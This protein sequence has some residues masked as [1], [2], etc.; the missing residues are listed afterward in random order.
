MRTVRAE[1]RASMLIESMRDFGY[2]LESAVA[3][4]VDNSIT[5]RALTV[6]IFADSTGSEPRIG[7][8]DDGEGMTEAELLL[9]MRLGSRNPLDNRDRADLGRFGLG[10]KTATFSQCRRLTVATRRDGV[11]SVARWDLDYVAE[12]DEWLVQIPDD[13]GSIPWISRLGDRGT[14]VVWEHLDRVVDPAAGEEGMARFIRR[15]DEARSH[16]ELVFHRFLAGELRLKRIRILL[17]ERPLEPFDP[18]NANH[19][20]TEHGQVE[21]IKLGDH[22]ITVQAFTLPHNRNVTAADWE[23]YA[24]REGYLKNQGFYVYREKRL[25]MHGTWFGLARQMEL[26]KLAR[27]RI[28]IPNGLDAHWKIDVRKASAQPPAPVRERLRRIIEPLGAA[29]KRVYTS[30]GTRLVSDNRLPVWT[31]LLADGKIVYRLNWDHPVLADFMSRLPAG[32]TADFR[33]VIEIAGAALPMDA[34]FADL[35]G[36]PERVAGNTLSDASLAYAVGKAHDKLAEAGQSGDSI[37]EMLRVA[38]PFRSNWERVEELLA[39]LAVD[40]EGALDV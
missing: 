12:T 18:F 1:P 9:A 19:P 28:D 40:K 33:E 4:V 11:T 34:L 22:R 24:G 7:I 29:S 27:V 16:L 15:V 6:S 30:R 20:A 21:R 14:L 35:G 23:R 39:G 2:S 38:E 31:R 8:L 36:E 25:I 13:P 32:L 10:L 37:A 26:T 5:A 3:D 17:N